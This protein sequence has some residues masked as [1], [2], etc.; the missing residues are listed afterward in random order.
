MSNIQ[1]TYIIYNGKE[2]W[3]FKESQL[4]LIIFSSFPYSVNSE[5][6]PE[7]PRFLTAMSS[8]RSDDVTKFVCVQSF[9]LIWS[10]QSLWSKMFFSPQRGSFPQFR[11]CHHWPYCAQ[12]INL[13]SDC[14][15]FLGLLNKDL[16]EIQD[17]RLKNIM[18]RVQLYNISSKHI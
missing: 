12:E 8:S 3:I 15:C 14:S 10:I 11:T 13:I 18:E 17:R 7:Q 1:S 2:W 6:F 4:H 9:F 5:P 16:C